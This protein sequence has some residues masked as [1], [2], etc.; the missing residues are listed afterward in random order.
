MAM[1]PVRTS[2]S[3][4]VVVGALVLACSLAACVGER[5]QRDSSSAKVTGSRV[6]R[7]GPTSP[8]EMIDLRVEL[9]SPR[10]GERDAFAR[11]VND[12]TSADYR[13]YLTPA[14]YGRRFGPSD[15]DITTVGR[16][17]TRNGIAVVGGD[18]QRTTLAARGTAARVERL[19]GIALDDYRSAESAIPF[20]L[21]SGTPLLPTSVDHLVER[22]TGLDNEPIQQALAPTT[23]AAAG[24]ECLTDGSCLGPRQLAKAFRYASLHDGRFKGEKQEVAII[25]WSTPDPKDIAQWGSDVG[26]DTDHKVDTVLVGT[27][28]PPDKIAEDGR[29]EVTLDVES[30]LSVAPNAHITVYEQPDKSYGSFFAALDKLKEGTHIVNFS[31]GGCD[32]P[33]ATD[34]DGNLVMPSLHAAAN[35]AF[36]KLASVGVTNVFISSGDS[37]AYTCWQFHPK[38]FRP[39]AA[40]PASVPGAIAVGGTSLR[41]AQDGTYVSESA[42][43]FPLINVGTGGGINPIDER[44]AWQTGPGV[45]PATPKDN[46][47]IPDVAAPADS[48]T[49]WYLVFGGKAVQVS[50]TSASSPFWAGL[51][52][53]Y[54]QKAGNKHA[55]PL[56]FL[57][58]ILY[59]LAATDQRSR[60]FHDI[61]RG[62]NLLN[63]ATPGW[64]YATGLGSPIGDKLGDAIIK[65]LKAR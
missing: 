41:R 49:M 45:V 42:W 28:P 2:R 5:T 26:V 46:R 40:F 13:H 48:N 4:V 57:N 19:L 63:D 54:Q 38:D 18:S 59:S 47:L 8:G 31:A 11:A 56:P 30:V 61:V 20:H 51:T 7:V 15:G 62:S 24:P 6:I 43:E 58:P 50:G 52:A 10:P 9:R 36:E 29:L 21:H 32:D 55:G 12:P 60:L 14:Q 33:D 65:Y 53:L 25:M 27:D 35:R 17:L 39:L 1:S 3:A 23:R 44:P 16:W 37:G 34:K 64:D 22:V